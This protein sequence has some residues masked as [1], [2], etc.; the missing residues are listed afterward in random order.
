MKDDVKYMFSTIGGEELCFDLKIDP[1]E[2][3]NL[4]GSPKYKKQ[5]EDLK[6]IVMN[7]IKNHA[8]TC[9]K[10]GKIVT[11]RPITSADEIHKWPGFHSISESSD[12]LH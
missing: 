5:I 10:D 8:P 9:V 11:Q 1:M 4:M 2:Q 7:H 6:S 3:H 12:L